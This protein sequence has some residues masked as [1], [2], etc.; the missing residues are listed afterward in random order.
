MRKRRQTNS[1]N[2]RIV[3]LT[4][5]KRFKP[6]GKIKFVKELIFIPLVFLAV[7]IVLVGT[8]SISVNAQET[9]LDTN[10]NNMTGTDTNNMTGTDT[11]NTG[12][13]ESGMISRKD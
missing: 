6:E 8:T 10:T 9:N 3:S 5:Q 4:Y 13:P 7:T 2:T 11:N 12:E 1:T